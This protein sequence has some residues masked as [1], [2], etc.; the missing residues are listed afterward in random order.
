MLRRRRG[1]PFPTL[2]NATST[3]VAQEEFGVD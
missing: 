3:K 2:M 1:E